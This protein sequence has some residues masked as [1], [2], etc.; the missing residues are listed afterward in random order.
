ME[1]NRVLFISGSIGLGHAGRDVAIAKALRALDPSVQISWLAG[2]SARQLIADAGETLLPESVGDDTASAEQI[3]GHFAL[4]VAQYAWHARSA[5]AHNVARFKQVIDEDAFDLVV[6]DETYELVGAFAK[7]PALKR[8]PFVMIY[9]FV[10]LDRASHNPLERLLVHAVNRSWS[11][12]GKPP[13]E[14]LALM[15]GE[16]A[17]VP[18]RPFGWRLP[19]RRQYASRYYQFVGYI[20][21]FD[22]AA[23]TDRSSLRAALGYDQRP[24][25]VCS[26]GGTTV[27]R[28]LLELCAA[29]HPHIQEQVHDV[30]MIL[31]CGP[32]LDPATITAPAGV[33]IR[34]YLPR[35]FEHLAACDLA[36]V[37]RGG[38]TTLELTALRRPFIYFPL[39]AHFEQEVMVAGRIQ[40]QQAGQRLRYADTTPAALATSAIRLLASDPAWPPIRCDGAR[41]AAELINALLPSPQR[42]TA[43]REQL[44]LDQGDIGG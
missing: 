25:L 11:R 37:Q 5:W 22:P 38:T 40:R 2:D 23:Y 31:V 21:Q 28:E 36:I 41:R 43:S 24:L 17:D 33:E 44:A 1:G 13:V 19:N 4:N 32:R 14:D 16:P 6:G 34:G 35:L 15:I 42:G 27:G 8:A 29:A 9:D 7:D 18:N 3:A 26:I 12:G 10:G 20:L 39:Q 30:R